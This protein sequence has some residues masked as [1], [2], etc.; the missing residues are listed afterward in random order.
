VA[1][2]GSSTQ[3]LTGQVAEQITAV[4]GVDGC[5]FVPAATGAP[6]SGTVLHRDGSVTQRSTT[7][8]PVPVDVDRHGLPTDDLVALAVEHDGVRYGQFLVTSSTRHARPTV[9]QRR[10]AATLA[11]QVGTRLAMG[12]GTAAPA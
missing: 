9:E 6:R 2:H 1:L 10:V 8:T 12:A 7:P 4:L 3:V 11:D 5:R